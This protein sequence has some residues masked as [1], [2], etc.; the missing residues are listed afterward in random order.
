[1][2]RISIPL[3]FLRGRVVRPGENISNY[4][5]SVKIKNNMFYFLHRKNTDLNNKNLVLFLI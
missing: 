1:M 5:Q 4:A 2:T 3:I